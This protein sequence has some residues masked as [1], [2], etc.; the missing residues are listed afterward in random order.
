M[1][2]RQAILTGLGPILLASTIG[3]AALGADWPQWR[4]PDRNG[5]SRETGL[6]KDWPAEGPKLVWQAHEIGDGYSTPAVV[7][8]RLYVMANKGT[9]DEFVE[10]LDTSDSHLVWSTRVGNV[11]P[12]GI[13]QYPGAR[14]TPT[15]DGDVLY[16]L[17]SDGDLACIELASGKMRWQKS[18]RSDFG[19]KPG[20]WAYSE[21]PLLDGDALV[22]TPG[23]SEATIVALHKK[24]GDVIWKSALPEGD[25]AAYA[26]AIAVE[27]GGVPQYVQFL[28]GGLV[29]VEA[30]SGKLLW[31]YDR[32]AKGSPANIPT[33]VALR[34]LVYSGAGRSGGALVE[35]KL[36]DDM[37]DASEVYFTPKLPTSI[38]GAVLVEG[39][40]YGSNGE[41]MV[42]ADFK[43]GE[44]KWQDRGVGAGGV[45]YADGRLYVHG[46]KEGEVAL[47]EATPEAYREKG[48]FAPPERPERGKSKS[49]AYPVVANGRL[50]IRDLGAL[51]CYDI[52]DP[53][54]K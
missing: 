16:A 35:L 49:W 3:A 45:C 46:E 7:G 2:T 25:K 14:S 18:L 21:S 12:N 1:N 29:G 13:P 32:T 54:A 38:G 28:A 23:G 50:Y 22:C 41:A 51:W 37:I 9:D 53:Q 30:K 44:I 4:G 6:L 43:T 8:N 48:R 52:K 31:R 47:I 15:V 20:T 36:I 26:S 5:I 39:S 42:C 10:A 24:T 34:N 11:G 33:P 19:G 40:L 17:G 27:A